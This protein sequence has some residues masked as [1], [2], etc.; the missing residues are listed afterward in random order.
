[1]NPKFLTGNRKLLTGGILAAL[2]VIA[3]TLVF[4]SNPFSA[5]ATVDDTPNQIAH[6]DDLGLL[7]ASEPT[8]SETKPY[9]GVA[10]YPMD[11]GSVKVVKVMKGGPSDGVLE[12]GD[13]ITAVNGQTLAG[14]TDLTDA[15]TAA[16]AGATLT[17]TV[18]R[19]GSSVD[20]SV[21]IGEFEMKKRARF[22]RFSG[23]QVVKPDEDGVYRTVSGDIT[24]LDSAAGTLTVQPKDGSAPIDYAVGDDARIFVGKQS[25]DDLSGLD[26]DGQ[27]VVV[28]VDGQV[29][30]VMQPSADGRGG[31]FNKF[32]RGFG[33]FKKGHKGMR[34]GFDK[35]A[36]QEKMSGRDADFL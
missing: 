11:D 23:S 36:L 4:V 13:V 18:T 26:T 30:A 20:V 35:D 28:D 1:M 10:I 34:G 21:T 29:K 27:A 17:L 25:V 3:V 12:A 15:I 24:A 22:D 5:Q 8:D 9:I 33:F 16:R 2:A 32:K 31:F 7:Q 14:K 19:D 6:P